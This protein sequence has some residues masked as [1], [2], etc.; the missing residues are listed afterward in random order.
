MLFRSGRNSQI[1]HTVASTG[2]YFLDAGAYASGTGSYVIA[3]TDVTLADD[4]AAGTNTTGSVAVGGSVTGV[5]ETA[6]D[7][8]WF[9]IS[10]SAGQ[11]YRFNLNGNTLSDPTLSLRNS[12]GSQVAYNDDFNGN[13]SQITFTATAT[14][15]YYLDAGHYGS[16]TGSYTLLAANVTPAP[17]NDD[18]S[19]SV[20]T[21]GTVNVG[22]NAVGTVNFIGDRD[23]FRITLAA[24]ATYQFNL[25]GTGL[26]DPTLYL[27]DA[28]GAQ[29]RFNDDFSGRNSQITFTTT[30]ADRKSTRL[31]SSHSSVSRMPSSA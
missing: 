30:T 2:S 3:V 24:G 26:S 21:T 19:A 25:D 12:A 29:L 5:V 17:V 11:T 23:W 28:A 7:R 22:G 8:D 1:T 10:L 15:T 20:S 31:N 4:Y 16:G 18:F 6:G 13:D 9:R 27:R 14:G